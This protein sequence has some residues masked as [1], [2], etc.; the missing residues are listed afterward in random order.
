MGWWG[1]LPSLTA[2]GG[3]QVVVGDVGGAA[4]ISH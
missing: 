4:A 2:T 1:V 3:M